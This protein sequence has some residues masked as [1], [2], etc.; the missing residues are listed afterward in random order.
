MDM[1][2]FR[3]QEREDQ[4]DL[5]QKEGAYIGKRVINEHSVILYQFESFYV[6]LYYRKYRKSLLYLKYSS[7]TDILHPYLAQIGV[8]ELV[9]FQ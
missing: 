8:N 2:N 5:L 7:S 4:L 1:Y 6:E 9:N 3:L